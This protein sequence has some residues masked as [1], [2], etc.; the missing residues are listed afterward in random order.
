MSDSP[1]RLAE[2]AALIDEKLGR[3]GL[4][5][6]EAAA[7]SGVSAATLSRVMNG[8]VPDTVT[9]AA[10][11]RWLGVSADRFIEHGPDFL[12]G[13]LSGP[14]PVEAHLRADRA[15]PPATAKALAALVRAAYD[16]FGYPSATPEE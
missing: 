15:L 10:L 13:Q 4:K 14:G 3:E 6:R 2:L 16:D 1:L 8:K 5:L 7:A 12:E 9:F 11:V